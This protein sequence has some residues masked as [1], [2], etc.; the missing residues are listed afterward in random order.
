MIKHILVES[1]KMKIDKRYPNNSP[2]IIKNGKVIPDNLNDCFLQRDLLCKEFKYVARISRAIYSDIIEQGYK[3]FCDE[4]M[5]QMMEKRVDS[6]LLK[7]GKKRDPVNLNIRK[8]DPQLLKTNEK[9][10]VTEEDFKN[11][12]RVC[13]D[14]GEETMNIWSNL[15]GKLKIK[16]KKILCSAKNKFSKRKKKCI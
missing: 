1:K 4:M 3:E 16:K 14:L 8:I 2:I 12:E 9:L 11:W 10:K 6:I 13:K 7:Y 15:K 5:E